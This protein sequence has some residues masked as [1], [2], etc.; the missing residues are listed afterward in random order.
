[1]LQQRQRSFQEELAQLRDDFSVEQRFRI[2]RQKL[3]PTKFV[4]EEVYELNRTTGEITVSYVQKKGGQLR[5]MNSLLG[6]YLKGRKFEGKTQ[7]EVRLQLLGFVV[8]RRI[9]TSEDLTRWECSIIIGLLKV[10]IDKGQGRPQREQDP[11]NNWLLSEYGGWFLSECEQSIRQQETDIRSQ[12]K[13]PSS[14]PV[15]TNNSK[16][17]SGLSGLRW[18]SH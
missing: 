12:E 9:G 10:S 16:R 2:E 8:G 1:M 17:A 5:G 3:P 18:G 11:E 4:E 6:Q 13:Q 15:Q 14:N 7:K